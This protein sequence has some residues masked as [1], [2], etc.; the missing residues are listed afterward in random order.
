MRR[1]KVIVEKHLKDVETNFQMVELKQYLTF[2]CQFILLEHILLLMTRVK[3]H[4]FM[5][6]FL[7]SNFQLGIIVN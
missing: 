5:A 7:I 4:F 3:V 6:I 2:I 1:S